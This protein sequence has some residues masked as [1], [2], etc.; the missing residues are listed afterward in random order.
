MERNPVAPV[1][2]PANKELQE[3]WQAE[4]KV[5]CRDCKKRR[6]PFICRRCECLIFD[7]CKKCHA[8]SEHQGRFIG[9]ATICPRC[10]KITPAPSYDQLR[11]HFL[12]VIEMKKPEDIAEILTRYRKPGQ[13]RK[14][15]KAVNNNIRD[16]IHTCVYCQK[17]LFPQEDN[18]KVFACA[19]QGKH[20]DDIAFKYNMTKYKVRQ[21]LQKCKNAYGMD[22]KEIRSADSL[23]RRLIRGAVK[24]A[25]AAQ[26]DALLHPRK[27]KHPVGGYGSQREP[28]GG[29]VMPGT[30]KDDKHRRLYR[31]HLRGKK[32]SKI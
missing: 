6:L 20:Q 25:S 18:L 10:G 24:A 22:Y 16:M 31:E 12:R 8:N 30:G 11:V 9:D 21:I 7:K 2:I 28:E 13:K 5:T 17:W 3:I 1:N 27:A 19:G 32:P 14:T 23:A 29:G 4:E 26:F 15:V